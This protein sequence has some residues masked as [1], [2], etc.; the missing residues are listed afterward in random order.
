MRI[1]MSRTHKRWQEIKS[2][3]FTIF[4]YKRMFYGA[5]SRCSISP[6]FYTYKPEYI[7]L[8]NGVSFGPSCRIEAHPA[9]TRS[10]VPKP[11]LKIGNRVRLEHGVNISCHQ[12]LIIEDHA[13]IAGGC[14]IG[15]NNHMTDPLGPHYAEQGLVG[16]ATFIGK[17]A[18]LGQ[19]VCVLAGSHIGER[20]IIGAGSVVNG[21][22]PPYS[23]A[24]GSPAKVVKRYDF[25]Q[26]AWKRVSQSELSP[27]LVISNKT[28]KGASG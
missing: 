21:Y 9:Q 1:W 24:V 11:L 3:L 7:E 26:S 17:G 15:D 20:A 19:N 27:T 10:K 25:E 5:G 22:I 2:R 16:S 23:V 6:P 4:W 28:E 18:W 13:L 8:G 12:S 14:Y